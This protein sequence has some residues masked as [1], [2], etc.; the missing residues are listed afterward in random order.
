MTL[1]RRT[2]TRALALGS[3]VGPLSSRAQAAYPSKPIRIVCP[4]APGGGSD[5]IARVASTRLAERLGQPVVVENRPGAGGTLG[6]EIGVRAA[7]DGYTLLLVAGSYTVNPAL[8]KLNFDP[9]A[10]IAPVIQLSRGA[11][12]L[13][14]NPKLSVK[15][16]PE[17]LALLR[18]EPGKLTFASSGLGG[19]LHVVT[20]YLLDLA[21]AKATHIPYKGTGPAIND[22]L[23]GNVDMLFGGTEGMM[24]HVKA[25]K[26]RA[27]A[28]STAGRLPSYPDIPSVAESGLPDYDVVAWHGLVA[29]K[30][31]PPAVIARLNSELNAVLKAKDM[32]DRLEPTGVGAAGGTPE[33][34]GALLQAEILRYGKV[35]RDAG[36]RTE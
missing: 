1:D 7:P 2:F 22:L 32:E 19:H 8:Y 35:V 31:V 33:Q 30:G 16:L 20:E 25:G 21:K 5:F 10:D 23:A 13:C 24:Q 28:V 3:L 17:L 29:P 11:Y 14:V 15:T 6:T 27:L 4:F 34:F 12:V 36:I 18:K 26:L 9:V